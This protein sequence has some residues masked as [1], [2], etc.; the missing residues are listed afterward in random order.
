[1]DHHLAVRSVLEGNTRASVY[2]DDRERPRTALALVKQRFY[3]AG[4]ARDNRINEALGRLFHDTIFPQGVE[5]EEDM[6][7]L[8]YAPDAW[9]EPLGEILGERNPIDAL[10][11]YY[12]S[13]ELV[14]YRAI[15][16]WRATLP[17]GFEMEVVDGALLA[18]TQLKNH[19]RL[20]EEVCS[21]RGSV[22]EFLDKSFG[23]CVVGGDELVAWCLSEYNTGQRCEVG[24]ET[25]EP[26]RRQGLG[27]A[28]A[29]ALVEMAVSK[30]IRH[31]GW[32]CYASNAGSVGTALR[33]GLQ[34]VC[35]YPT[36]LCWYDEADHLAVHGNIAFRA[37]EYGQALTWYE[38]AFRRGGARDWAYWGAACAAALM[39][40]E[41][42]ALQY[43]AQAVDRGLTD[44]ERLV[45]SE[46]LV[47]LHDG[48]EWGDLVRRVREAGKQ[49]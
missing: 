17:E 32:H 37:G 48:A 47:S 1:M 11:Q 8:Y 35:D 18:R 39:G 9:A 7:V 19:D 42:D 36:F 6:F 23:V 12:T 33:V 49:G 31:V 41:G 10:R 4:E 28:A 45:T 24:I 15:Q 44:L 46:H 14:G 40:Q 26:Y 5:A 20:V 43:L 3:L 22:G 21:E 29:A 38:Q 27:Q 34:K 25:M 30:G 13:G 16:D 2:V